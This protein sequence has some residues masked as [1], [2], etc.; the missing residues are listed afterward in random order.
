MRRRHGSLGPALG[1]HVTPRFVLVTGGMS[2]LVRE[3]GLWFVHPENLRL[4]DVGNGDFV[5]GF[6]TGLVN[7]TV[8]RKPVYVGATLSTALA[9]PWRS[10]KTRTSLSARVQIVWLLPI[11]S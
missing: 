1:G 9:E 3:A 4:G 8:V 6:K 10:G 11:V 5:A 2:L 7:G